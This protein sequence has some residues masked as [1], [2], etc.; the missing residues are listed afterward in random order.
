MKNLLKCTLAFS[1]AALVF[2]SCKK[3]ENQV[4]YEGG[5][6]PALTEV[7]TTPSVLLKVNENNIVNTFSWTNPNYRFNTGISSQDVTYTIQIDTVGANFTSPMLGEKVISKELGTT[8]TVKELN[9]ILLTRGLNEDILHHLEIRLKSSLVNSTAVLYSA[10]IHWDVT[11]YLDVKVTLPKD[12]PTPN[13]NDG[14]L[15]LVGDAT[16]GGWN[17]PVPVPS[18]KFTQISNVEYQIITNL[19]GGKQYLLL[20]KNG[21]WS[22]KY[23]ITNT[24]TPVPSTGGVFGADLNDNFNGPSASG[25][26][27]IDV[28][29]KTGLFT[30]TPH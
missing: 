5:T 13:S 24:P 20:P 28:N 9:S 2:S 30:V 18:Q 17:N 25:S 27:L 16:A 4:I 3:E 22:H 8:I 1:F 10:P 26:Y 11:P 7:T 6:A 12:L 14:S 23:A 29:F 15:F 19:I 21:D